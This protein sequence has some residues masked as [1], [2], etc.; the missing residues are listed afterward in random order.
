MDWIL[1]LRNLGIFFLF[2]E[3]W[4]LMRSSLLRKGGI[5]GAGDR[6]NDGGAI[7]AF[8]GGKVLRRE[9]AV[10]GKKSMS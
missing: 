10:D 8:C 4:A 6:G 7:S 3:P 2:A 9:S 5:S 1:D